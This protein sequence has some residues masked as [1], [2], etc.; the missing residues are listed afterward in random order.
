[1][2][3]FYGQ[4]DGHANTVAS[5]RGTDYIKSSAQSYDGSV[6]TKLN[7]DSQDV[8]MVTISLAKG[9]DFYGDTR[10][11]PYFYGTFEQLQECFRD[12]AE[13]EVIE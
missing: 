7:Y 5:R 13:R 3:T 8:L 2:S 10:E 4:V 9:S 11:L 12:W 1:M 6:I